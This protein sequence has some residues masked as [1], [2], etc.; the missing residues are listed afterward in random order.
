VTNARVCTFHAGVDV[1]RRDRTMWVLHCAGL[2]A[3]ALARR[4]DLSASRVRQ[5]LATHA[6][7]EREILDGNP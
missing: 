1:R 4:F 3:P 2:R 5:I 7:R 6:A